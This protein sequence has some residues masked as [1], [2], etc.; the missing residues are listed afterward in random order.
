MSQ[1]DVLLVVLDDLGTVDVNATLTPN[2]SAFVNSGGAR[3]YT[4][5][6]SMPLCSQTRASLLFGKYGRTLGIVDAMTVLNGPEPGIEEPTLPNILQDNGYATCLVGKW[7]VGRNPADTSLQY[8]G[9]PEVRGFGWWLAGTPSNVDNYWNWLRVDDDVTSQE[10]NYLTIEQ[11]ESAIAWWSATSGPKFMQVSLNAPHGPYH[12]PPSELLGGFTSSAIT[13]NRQKYECQIRSA[14]WAFSEILSAIGSD[15]VVIVVGDNGTPQNT[16]GT[17]Q[18]GLSLKGTC[19]EGG[20][21]VPLAIRSQFGGGVS[22]R[23]VHVVD[24]PGSILSV[25]GIQRPQSWDASTL[26]GPA[27]TAC[28]SE[29]MN[30]GV[31]WRAA[32]TKRYK[33]LRRDS[34]PEE[35]YDL[36]VD[37]TEQNKLDLNDPLYA[38]TLQTLRGVLYT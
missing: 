7:H 30:D 6:Y 9:A 19:Y 11:V 25:A 33:L 3:A 13:Q 37:P 21:R 24:I 28:L 1:P 32:M 15:T 26:Y 2:L 12:F 22:D 18:A 17:S 5:C 38:S 20:I 8:L 34:A 23:L 36:Q 16:P 27:R 4:R 29:A 10:T 35:L 31:L 14:D